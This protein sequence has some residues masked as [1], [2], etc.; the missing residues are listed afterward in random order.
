MPHLGIGPREPPHTG[1]PEMRNPGGSFSIPG[2]DAVRTTKEI[3]FKRLLSRPLLVRARRGR[4]RAGKPSWHEENAPDCAEGGYPKPAITA[5]PAAGSGNLCLR[6]ARDKS[7][8][9]PS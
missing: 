9:Q 3:S 6:T 7:P 5:G 8:R 1:M 2:S 4:P